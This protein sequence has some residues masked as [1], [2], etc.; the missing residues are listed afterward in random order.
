MEDP[1]GLQMLQLKK[2]GHSMAVLFNIAPAQPKRCQTGWS[3]SLT[4]YYPSQHILHPSHHKL[5]PS[6]H[7]PHPSTHM[8][9][10]YMYV[11]THHAHGADAHIGHNL[12]SNHHIT[13]EQASILIIMTY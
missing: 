7:I 3:L 9:T 10:Q 6:Q 2:R 12:N 11:C 4:P 5:H 8:D 13:D 1:S